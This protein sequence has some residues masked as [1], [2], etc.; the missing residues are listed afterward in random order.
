MGAAKLSVLVPG[1][2]RLVPNLDP[3][4]LAVVMCLLF[5]VLEITF[6]F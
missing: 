3:W 1:N 5:Q 2:P 6:L 4:T